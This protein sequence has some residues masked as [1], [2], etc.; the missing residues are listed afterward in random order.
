MK[1]IN[2]KLIHFEDGGKTMSAIIHND[3]FVASANIE[4]ESDLVKTWN[5]EQRQIAKRNRAKQ[6]NDKN[7]IYRRFNLNRQ[8][9]ADIQ[10]HL[11]SLDISVSSY[12]KQLIREDMNRYNK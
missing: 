12:I 8:K 5:A 3:L 4:F 6:F 1:V 9:D 7:T 10:N 2:G 11:D